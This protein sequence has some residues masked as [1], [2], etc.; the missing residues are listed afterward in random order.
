MGDGKQLVHI[1][2]NT[3][4]KRFRRGKVVERE[5]KLN[6]QENITMAPAQT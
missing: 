3:D 5:N 1:A 6:T 2:G 4:R